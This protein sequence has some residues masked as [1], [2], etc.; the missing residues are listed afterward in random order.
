MYD[1]NVAARIN[2]YM[3]RLRKHSAHW[4]QEHTDDYIESQLV[5][6]LDYDADHQPFH[7]GYYF[8]NCERK[9]LFWGS[10]FDLSWFLSEVKGSCT[11]EHARMFGPR[12]SFLEKISKP[13]FFLGGYL[14]HEFWLVATYC[15][16]Y[17]F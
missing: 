6:K 12:S 3:T 10:D 15:S 11:D 13:L 2:G 16:P 8:A 17:N 1:I 4:A 7:C 14:L 9:L 5:L